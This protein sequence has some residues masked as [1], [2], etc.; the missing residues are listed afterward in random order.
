M[1]Q[2][3]R[4]LTLFCIGG[5]CILY[6]SCY[7]DPSTTR[8][9]KMDP[10]PKIENI[11][12]IEVQDN[13]SSSK[14]KFKLPRENWNDLFSTLLPA[15]KDEDPKKWVQLATLHIVLDNKDTKSVELFFTNEELGAFAIETDGAPIYYR[16]GK[17]SD[18]Q[19]ILKKAKNAVL[20]KQK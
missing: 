12:S 1:P 20:G 4:F 7:D 13:T 11:L 18:M 2:P 14:E 10:L 8:D 5:C 19:N 17:S 16:G 3:S 9:D 15:R 6:A